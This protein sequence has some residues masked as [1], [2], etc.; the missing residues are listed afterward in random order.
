MYVHA[1]SL[2]LCLI[3][4]NPMDYRLPGS[5]VYG[6]L[7][8]RILEWS[9]ICPPPGDLPDSGIELTSLYVSCSATLEAPHLKNGETSYSFRGRNECI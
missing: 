5:S 2:Q 1:K 9:A 7:Q 6:I 3:L 4:C 8:A